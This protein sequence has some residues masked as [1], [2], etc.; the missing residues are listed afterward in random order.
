MAQPLGDER[1]WVVD[2]VLR[3]GALKDHRRRAA[4]GSDPDLTALQLGQGVSVSVMDVR[5]CPT[6]LVKGV[7]RGDIR[8]HPE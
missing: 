3:A 5:A 8:R 2:V 7:T 6:V 1:D 4:G